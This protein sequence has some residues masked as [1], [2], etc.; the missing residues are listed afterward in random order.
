MTLIAHGGLTLG[1]CVPPA[2]AAAV[3][4]AADITPKLEGAIALQTSLTLTPPSLATNL[5][6][7][8]DLVTSLQASITLG[9]PGVD[10]QLLAV[11]ELIATLEAQFALVVELQNVL[12]TAGVYAYSLTGAVGN[13]GTEVQAELGGGVAGGPPEQV[14][15]AWLFVATAPAAIVAAGEVFL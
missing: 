5:T 7:A 1:Q 15:A 14:G 12:G 2:N 13:F 10:F 8:M 6:A 3:A 9:L 4:L 11:A